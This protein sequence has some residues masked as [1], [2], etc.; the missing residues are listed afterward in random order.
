MSDQ[1]TSQWKTLISTI[2]TAFEFFEEDSDDETEELDSL[3]LF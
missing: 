3:I 1:N 2:I